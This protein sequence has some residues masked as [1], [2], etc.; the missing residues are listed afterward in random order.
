MNGTPILAE[1]SGP[2]V[3][4]AVVGPSLVAPLP[5]R[6]SQPG[7]EHP[8]PKAPGLAGIRVRWRCP[9][10]HVCGR[11]TYMRLDALFE[12]LFIDHLVDVDTYRMRTALREAGNGDPR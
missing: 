8:F 5:T 12:H 4:Q 1:M 3:E 6:S 10:C 7:G 9:I 2:V 11:E